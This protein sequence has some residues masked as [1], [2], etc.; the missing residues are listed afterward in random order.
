MKRPAIVG[1]ERRG[2]ERRGSRDRRGERGVTMVLVATAL[3]AIMA[4]AALSIDVVTLYLANAEAQRSADAAALA[5]A[6]ILSLTGMT[7]D[8]ANGTLN[9]AAACTLATQVAQAVA[10]QNLVGGT[11]PSPPNVTFP[12]NGS[13]DCSD[14][15]TSVFGV[16]PIVQVQVQRTNLPTFFARIW[17][18]RGATVSATATAEAYNPS[19][20]ANF[21]FAGS[22]VPVQPRCA[23]PWIIA[24]EEPAGSTFI[25]TTLGAITNP[26]IQLGRVG[27]TV[28]GKQFTLTPACSGPN[29]FAA[30]NTHLA[31]G[32][33]IPASVQ[34][35]PVSIPSACA[36]SDVYQ[37]AIDGCDQTTVY[38]CGTPSGATADLTFNPG[39]LAG[40]TSTAA[41]CLIHQSGGRD[42]LNTSSFPFQIQAGDGNPL[43]AVGINASNVITAS[44]SIV[45][46]PI[47]DNTNPVGGVPQPAVTI[48]GFLQVFIDGVDGFG[49]PQVTILNVSGCSNDAA[50]TGVTGSSPVPVRLI[51]YP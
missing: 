25:D 43:I 24:N 1:F 18:H 28:I 2:L 21:A 34:G 7:G 4:M 39:G 3:V 40:D 5:A 13:G 11:V 48:V 50:T 17:G 29:C 8:P 33:Y 37:E 6:R 32:S 26:G 10:N 22:M 27:T 15:G 12:N 42:I 9:W 23:K 31:P 14:S 49:N 38:A 51:K 16:N 47:M 44:N 36:N 41:Q 30:E 46:I 35:T 19:N 45:T 20:S